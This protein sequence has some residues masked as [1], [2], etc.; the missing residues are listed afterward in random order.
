MK[1]YDLDSL[2][3]RDPK[4]VERALRIAK[5]ILQALFQPEVRGIENVPQ[6]AALYVG[7]HN[8]GVVMP[9][10][11]VLATAVHAA[12]GMDAVPYGLAHEIAIRV[13]IAHQML[14]PLGAVRASHDN[15]RRLFE[16]GKKV[17][18][19]PGSDI[20]TY[21][22]YRDRHRVIFGKRRG[23]VRLAL[24]SG[25]PIIPVVTAGAHETFY[26]ID[27]GRS[28]ARAL[29]L[30]KLLRVKV[31]PLILSVPYGLTLG[32]IP[33][34]LPLP[35]PIRMQ[36]L[37]PIHFDRSGEEAVADSDYVEQCHERVLG[38]MQATLT[39]L[40][41]EEGSWGGPR[42]RLERR[43]AGIRSLLGSISKLGD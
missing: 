25:V 34:H 8:S 38:E 26:V 21:R 31:W 15:G 27:D 12:H 14:V 39:S 35:S 22:P 4:A 2:D 7:N 13:P 29:R 9:E 1:Q 3:N 5:P 16:R 24:R 20:D 17:L 32:P 43:L 33:P 11:Y 23:Y 18:V 10:S 19:F 36:I 30:D 37:P 42:D 41:E 28:I 40:G 6:G